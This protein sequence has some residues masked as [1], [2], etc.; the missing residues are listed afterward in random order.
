[1][2]R[3]LQNLKVKVIAVKVTGQDVVKIDTFFGNCEKFLK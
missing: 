3:T 1:M 2:S